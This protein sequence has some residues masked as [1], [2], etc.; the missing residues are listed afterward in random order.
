MKQRFVERALD[1]AVELESLAD[2][3]AQSADP[4]ADRETV[5]RLAH[6]MAGSAGTFGFDQLTVSAARLEDVALSGVSTAELRAPIMAVVDE[7]RWVLNR[8]D[9]DA[10]SSSLSSNS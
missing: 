2:G 8:N 6:R 3:V 1:D 5:R 4:A 7:I 10:A 9:D